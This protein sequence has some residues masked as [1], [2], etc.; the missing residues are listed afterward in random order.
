MEQLSKAAENRFYASRPAVFENLGVASLRINDL[1]TAEYAFTRAI[2]LNPEQ[3][4]SLLELA[5]LR[6][7]ERKY[8][9][10]R[11]LYTRHTRVAPKSAKTLWLCIRLAR[12]YRD[13]NEEASCAEALEGLFPASEEYRLYRES[14]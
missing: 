3:P 6:F 8:V 11:E 14:R 10:S 12:V 13:I 2:Q 4:R 1:E 7:N 9:A 5:D